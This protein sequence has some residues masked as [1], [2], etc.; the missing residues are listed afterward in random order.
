MDARKAGAIQIL[1]FLQGFSCYS[2]GPGIGGDSFDGRERLLQV[3]EH[4]NQVLRFQN[5]VIRVLQKHVFA[6]V[7]EPEK[8]APGSFR[9]GS[10]V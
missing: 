10:I 9:Q 2:P 6:A 1:K 3:D 7:V 5:Q 8:D 4:F